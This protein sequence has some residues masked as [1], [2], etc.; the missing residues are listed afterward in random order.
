MSVCLAT[1]VEHFDRRASRC[2]TQSGQGESVQSTMLTFQGFRW[3]AER[4]SDCRMYDRNSSTSC[5]TPTSASGIAAP[6]PHRREITI[7]VGKDGM[8][9][10]LWYEF[11]A[12]CVLDS[13]SAFCV[14]DSN[15]VLDSISAAPEAASRHQ[16]LMLWHLS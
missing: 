1:A 12:F 9:R 8:W 5:S 13:N 7:R 16:R 15:S 4:D 10:N 11:L 3:P 14:L 6:C 2:V